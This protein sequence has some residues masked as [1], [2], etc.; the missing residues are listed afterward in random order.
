MALANGLTPKQDAFAMAY[1]ETGCAAEAYRHAYNAE[2]MAETTIWPN[3]SKLLKNNKVATRV[4]Q[5]K[6]R[7]QKRHDMTVDDLTEMLKSDREMA[8]DIKQPSAAVSAVM[9]MAKLHGLITDKAEHTG[10]D[11]APLMPSI[12][13]T[14]SRTVKQV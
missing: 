1:V 11:G 10:K 2:N 13:V 6:E 8:R 7:A 12:N 14:I 4:S 9:G 5:L 3:A